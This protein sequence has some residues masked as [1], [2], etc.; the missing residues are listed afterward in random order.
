MEISANQPPRPKLA[1]PSGT[2]AAVGRPGDQNGIGQPDG[3]APGPGPASE[4]GLPGHGAS[5]TNVQEALQPDAGLPQ[6][7][8]RKA[9]GLFPVL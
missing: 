8:M 5:T 3:S 1:A 4:R 2:A 7:L 6:A 9:V